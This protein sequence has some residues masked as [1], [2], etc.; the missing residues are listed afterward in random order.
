MALPIT[1]LFAALLA[2]LLVV[3][4]FRVIGVRRSAQVSL[5]TGGNATLEKRC[6]SQGNFCEYVPLALGLL[7]LLE[8]GGA[9]QTTLYALGG[10]LLVARLAHP[11]GIE[12]AGMLFRILGATGTFTVLLIEAVLLL[13]AATGV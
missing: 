13:R 9:G 1:S 12:G 6:R 5:G 7:A 8:V 2:L 10:G 3:L 11:L 4:S